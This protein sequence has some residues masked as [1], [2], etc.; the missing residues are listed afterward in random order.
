MKKINWPETLSTMSDVCFGVC[1]GLFIDQ[2]ANTGW[3]FTIVGTVAGVVLAIVLKRCKK[4]SDKHE[5]H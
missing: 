3:I 5:L 1:L 2:I 4:K